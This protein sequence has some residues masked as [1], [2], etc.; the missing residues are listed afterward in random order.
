MLNTVNVIEVPDQSTM[1]VGK[2]VSFPDPEGNS[3]AEDLFR[4]LVRENSQGISAGMIEEALEDGFF[5]QGTYWVGIVHS[6][7]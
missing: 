4:T 1:G 2:L 3:Q 6:T 7:E 5:W